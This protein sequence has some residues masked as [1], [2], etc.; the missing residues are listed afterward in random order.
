VHAPGRAAQ[1]AQG[2]TARSD[3][4]GKDLRPYTFLYAYM[5]ESGPLY[6]AAIENGMDMGETE[7]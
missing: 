6:A 3:G 7:L 2:P 5:A 4:G 1:R